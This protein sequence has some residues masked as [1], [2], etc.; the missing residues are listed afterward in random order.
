MPTA[1][2]LYTTTNRLRPVGPKPRNGKHRQ[3]DSR[4]QQLIAADHINP[5]FYNPKQHYDR[6]S[7]RPRDI[8]CV[9][10]SALLPDFLCWPNDE[11]Y[12]KPTVRMVYGLVH[13]FQHAER[14]F[15][16]LP[17]LAERQYRFLHPTPHIHSLRS[18][19]TG[20]GLGHGTGCH[21]RKRAKQPGFP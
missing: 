12:A 17:K 11:H 15:S 10:E 20:I 18:K 1:T 16:Q 19:Y 13:P 4:T 5:E 14:A 2:K 7:Q 9:L 6:S 21:H 3:F 8:D